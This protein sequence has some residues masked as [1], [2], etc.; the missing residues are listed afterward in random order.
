MEIKDFTNLR[1]PLQLIFFNRN[2]RK[3]FAKFAKGFLSK[4]N[5]IQPPKSPSG[6]KKP[7]LTPPKEGNSLC[8]GWYKFVK[9]L[10]RAF[11][12]LWG[13]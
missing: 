2:G 9:P 5:L 13:D 6:G 8:L 10:S 12:P 1:F 7:P 4:F 11:S 3:V